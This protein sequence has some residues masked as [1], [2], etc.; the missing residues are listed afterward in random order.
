MKKDDYFMVEYKGNG[1]SWRDNMFRC[2]AS[3]DR[4]VVGM[5]CGKESNIFTDPLT[6]ARSEWEFI[7]R[8]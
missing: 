2:I 4:A 8:P 5:M 1:K 6:F 3:D 7:L